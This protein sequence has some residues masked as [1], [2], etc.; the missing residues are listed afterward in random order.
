[1]FIYKNILVSEEIIIARFACDLDVCHGECCANGDAGAPLTTEEA[2]SFISSEKK[3]SQLPEFITARIKAHGAVCEIFNTRLNAP[4]YCT[5]LDEN[6]DCVFVEKSGGARF[7]YLQRHDTGLKKPA[8]CYLFPIREKRNE[9]MIILNLHVHRECQKCYGPEKP[10]L[11]EF[12]KPVL[13]EIYGRDFFEA[14]LAE[15]CDR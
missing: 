1:M 13:T 8:S 4:G 15:A 6:G 12:L 10:L 9:E 7:C 11:V 14:L 3:L 5:S 2:E